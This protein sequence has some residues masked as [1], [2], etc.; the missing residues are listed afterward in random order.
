MLP[1]NDR[2]KT[3]SLLF[4]LKIG[5]IGFLMLILMIPAH[6]I[7][8][9]IGERKNTQIQ[10]VTD[11]NK[12]WGKSQMI[13]GPI[14]VIPYEETS[15]I[16]K[17]TVVNTRFLYIFP[18]SLKMSGEI[19]PSIRKLGIFESI[20]NKTSLQV[21]GNFAGT[22]QF[23]SG[24][25]SSNI[26][27]KN[28]FIT[29]SLSSLRSLQEDVTLKWDNTSLNVAYLKDMMSEKMENAWTPLKGE[30]LYIPVDLSNT[31][32]NSHDFSLELKFNSSEELSFTPTAVKMDVSL[33]SSWDSP[34]FF[35]DYPALHTISKKGFQADWQI[36]QEVGKDFDTLLDKITDNGQSR[37]DNHYNGIPTFG[38]ELIKAV[39]VYQSAN[40]SIKYA[41]L[42]I[43]LTF[44]AYF[45]F[46]V[47]LKL[48]IHPLQYLLVGC[49]LS[50]FYLMLLA[51]S[52]HIS[53]GVAYVLSSIGIVGLITGYS[54]SI[55]K[56]G[57]RALLL[58]GLL[59]GLY[60]YLYILLRAEDFALLMGSLG[61]F[62]ILGFIMFI[63]RKINWYT[64]EKET[65]T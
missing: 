40:R 54:H 51:L 2:F 64:L 16:K 31:A 18:D 49:G 1:P 42:F 7:H 11:I 9:L 48:K 20:V 34:R 4:G 26:L 38:V 61:L 29:L 8:S 63:T 62:I 37:Y 43:L 59:S 24:I 55:L 5:I 15:I 58:G 39:D 22:N 27:W 44:V 47:V 3:S 56:Q 32:Q 46:E 12:I 28:S 33:L 25:R 52:E 23:P 14:L 19:S 35:G 13:I 10:A 41:A 36:R 50:L 45:L 30:S 17:E 57:K 60:I 6:M 21:S 53:F 65:N